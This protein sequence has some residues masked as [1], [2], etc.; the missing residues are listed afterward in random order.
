MQNSCAPIRG[1]FHLRC[2]LPLALGTSQGTLWPSMMG[3]PRM[4]ALEQLLARR[5]L[6]PAE[7]LPWLLAVLVYAFLPQ[8]RA[9]GTQVLIMVLFTFSLDVVLGYAGV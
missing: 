9:F 8:F 4:S 2:R 5:R 1:I 6:R 7:A 3:R